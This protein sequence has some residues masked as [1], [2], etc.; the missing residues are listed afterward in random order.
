ME[1]KDFP[2]G[3]G[4]KLVVSVL[5]LGL[6]AGLCGGFFLGSFLSGGG[7]G[8]FQFNLNIEG[9]NTLFELQQTWASAYMDVNPG[10][11][12]VVGGAGS[13]VGISQ[14]IAGIV[15]AADASRLPK[16]SEYSAA[17]AAG[18]NLTVI[19]VCIDGIV[20]VVHLSNPIANISLPLLRGI[21]N[22]SITQWGEVDPALSGLGAITAY[23]RNPSS[24]TF[25]YFQEHVMENDDYAATVNQLAGN[26]DIISAVAA[27]SKGIGYVGAAYAGTSSVK[28]IGVNDPDT[29]VPVEPTPANIMDFSY[30]I[31]RY[32][33]VIT[34]G[35][36]TGYLASYIDWCLGPYGQAIANMTGY[37]PVYS[38]T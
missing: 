26:S 21:Y 22:G 17:A 12:I 19:P 5:V 24:G 14:L 10:V 29:G 18:V 4:K 31:S 3:F 34:N 11:S 37:I 36:P 13:S 25:A 16:A 32:L 7:S 8:G 35:V 9:S 27:D 6:G 2:V 30:P 38:L 15:D 1:E 20:I 33:Y 28:V 23:S